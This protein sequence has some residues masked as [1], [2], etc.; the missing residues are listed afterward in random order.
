MEENDPDYKRSRNEPVFSILDNNYTEDAPVG[1]SESDEDNITV[2]A[3]NLI[4]RARE[5]YL[6]DHKDS[7]AS[8]VRLLRSNDHRY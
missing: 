4:N 1:S 7:F 3:T 2:V 6:L 5:Y 8:L